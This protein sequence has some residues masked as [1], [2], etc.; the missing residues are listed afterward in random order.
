MLS[1]QI[2]SYLLPITAEFLILHGD[3]IPELCRDLLN[4]LLAVLAEGVRRS[5]FHW[6]NG[7][8][9]TGIDMWLLGGQFRGPPRG[10]TSP[11]SRRR[12]LAAD[13]VCTRLV[14]DRISCRIDN[15][16][17]PKAFFFLKPAFQK[18]LLDPP[19]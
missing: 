17:S 6:Y 15:H 7:E 3:D 19:C 10:C 13:S 4:H 12:H 18:I 5:F 11:I 9:S 8:S 1:T 14:D 16:H 2:G